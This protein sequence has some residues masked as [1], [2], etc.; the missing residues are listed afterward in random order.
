VALEVTESVLVTDVEAT[1]AGLARLHALGIRLSI[2]DF[3]TGYASLD[4]VRRFSMADELKVD[5]SFV[6]DLEGSEPRDRAIVWASVVLA[7]ALG[8]TAVAEGVETERQRTV[9]LELG[10]DLGQGY[11]FSRPLPADEMERLLGIP[12]DP[13]RQ[14]IQSGFP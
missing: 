10:C 2:D 9:L 7:R 12:A 14:Q 6:A 1:A 13:L 3:G 11:F 8:L 5:R 4:A